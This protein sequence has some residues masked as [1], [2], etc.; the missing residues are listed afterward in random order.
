MPANKVFEALQVFL[1]SSY[2]NDFNIL[3]RTYEVIAQANEPLRR[4]PHD[5]GNLKTR[6]NAGQM[7]PLSAVTSRSGSWCWSGCQPR[8]PS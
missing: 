4:D 6:N 8:M 1:G 7:V 2:V 5:I 3:G